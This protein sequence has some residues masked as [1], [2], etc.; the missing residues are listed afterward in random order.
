MD[1]KNYNIVFKIAAFIIPLVV[2][3]M[4]LAPTVSFIDSG[5][6]ATVSIKLGVAHPTGYPLF[7]ILGNLFSKLPF[8]EP[9]YRLNLMCAIISSLT[10]FM[11]YNL[12][13]F[14]FTDFRYP[15]TSVSSK[16]KSKTKNKKEPKLSGLSVNLISLSAAFVLAFS[17]TFWNAAT[18]IEVY[19]LHTFFLVSLIYL[20]LMACNSMSE[21]STS[22]LHGE[23]YWLAFAFVLGLSFTN[24][25]STIFLGIGTLYF[26]FALNGFNSKAFK[27][28]A[29]MAIPF[30]IGLSV[31]SYL[32][33]RAGNPILSWGNTYN[34]SN[35]YAHV[36]GKQFSVWMFSSFDN[37][38][39]QFSHFI[40]ILPKEFFFVALII[41][42]PGLYYLYNKSRM[43]FLYTILLF[44]FTVIYAINYDIYD[45]DSYFLLAFIVLSIWVAYG[46][47]FIVQRINKNNAVQVSAATLLVAA[48]MLYSNY[49]QS[50]Q[51]D[52]YFVEDYTMNVFNSAPPNSIIFSVQWDFWVSASMYYQYIKN[53]RP[54]IVVIDKE[55]MRKSWYMDYIKLHY[56][57]IYDQ[58]KGQFDVY[59]PELIKF[60][61]NPTRYTTP[62]TEQDRQ[63]LQLIQMYFLNLLNCIVETNAEK[64]P[65]FTTYEIEQEGNERFGQEF[66]R[67]PQGLLIRYTKEEELPDYQ[68][69]EFKFTHTDKTSYHHSF[70]MNSYYNAYLNRA[71]YLMSLKK[72]DESEKMINLALQQ[73]PERNE[74]RQ[75]MNRLTQMKTSGN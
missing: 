3:I 51:S 28:I 73:F 38:G 36:S 58:C 59:M 27:R 40:E 71:S 69:P 49:S 63:D 61:A 12:L 32:L 67:I 19:S 14:L 68:Q 64:R 1:Q 9:I 66:N 10:V 41:A 47:Y 5:E 11:F 53:I 18:S 16:T 74:A 56:P 17:L 37:A 42:L 60:E 22:F 24:H 8:G 13:V 15:G 62:K 75:L 30:V 46:F 72:Y 54:D 7:T 39:R 6:L 57:D 20:F 52:N 65:V 43:F 2:Y 21:E 4:T 33:I 29:L 25:L 23:R 45:I 34:L 35:L 48:I 70:I 55:L 31:Y 50:D 26:Y 44:G